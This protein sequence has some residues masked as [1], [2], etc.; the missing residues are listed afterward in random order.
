MEAAAVTS[1]GFC[2]AILVFLV[3]QLAGNYIKQSL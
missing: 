1:R 3:L 2:N